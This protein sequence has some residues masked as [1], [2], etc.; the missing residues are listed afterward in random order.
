MLRKIYCYLLIIF[1]F[2]ACASEK[3][4]WKHAKSINT[5]QLYEDFIKAHP[6]GEFLDSAKIRLNQILP[7]G[8]HIDNCTVLTTKKTEC[9]ILLRVHLEHKTDSLNM[10]SGAKIWILLFMTDNVFGGQANISNI[11]HPSSH[12][13]MIDCSFKPAS[14]INCFGVMN[15]NVSVSDSSNNTMDKTDV[16]VDFK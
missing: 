13:T 9:E 11:S 10:A 1:F 6:K 15:M 7:A 3:K 4:E 14:L 8:I 5:V 2:A 16:I 12:S